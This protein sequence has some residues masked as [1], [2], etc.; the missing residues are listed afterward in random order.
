MCIFV[1]KM[2]VTYAVW[3]LSGARL[4]HSPPWITLLAFLVDLPVKLPRHSAAIVCLRRVVTRRK[5][6]NSFLHQTILSSDDNG[7]GWKIDHR[8]PGAH[9]DSTTES[10][11]FSLFSVFVNLLFTKYDKSLI[12]YI[13]PWEWV[14][15]EMTLEWVRGSFGTPLT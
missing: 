2:Y 14:P 11:L 7:A 12:F 10:D 15:I 4:T 6:I 1:Y 8:H 5:M 13:N 9:K 3:A